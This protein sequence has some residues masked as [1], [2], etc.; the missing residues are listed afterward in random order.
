MI[1][2][3][4]EYIK[5]VIRTVPNRPKEGIMFR[6]ITTLLKDAK[7]FSLMMQLLFQR[8]KDMKLEYI[9]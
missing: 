2:Q 4:K 5:S 8:Y 3:E 1:I 9:V 6:D 7:G